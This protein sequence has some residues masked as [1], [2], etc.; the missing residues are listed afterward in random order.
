MITNT[1]TVT[2]ATTDTNAT[3]NSDTATTTVNA[4]GQG[5][6]PECDITSLNSPRTPGSAIIQSDLDSPGDE[7]LLVTGTSKNDILIIEPRAANTTQVRVKNTGRL[8]GTVSNSSFQ[9]IVVYALGGNDTIV[10]DPR[11]TRPA[12]IFG[13]DGN[14]SLSGG[15]GNDQISGGNGND[16]LFGNNGNDTL[17]GEAG[18]DNL[19]G[20]NGD[21]LEFGE[22]GS[23]HLYGDAGKDVL[24]GGDD[25]D[26]LYGGIDNDQLFGQ[27]GNDQLYGDAGN[28]IIV[29]GA[30]N[31]KLYGS[32]GRDILIGGIGA[33]QLNG[34]T[35]D[36]ILTGDS[37]TDDESPDALAAI[38]KKW[39]A[40][41]AYNFRVTTLRSSL[42]SNTVLDDGAADALFGDIGQDWYFLGSRDKIRDRALGESI[43]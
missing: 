7:V 14:D 8:L 43:S 27:A 12:L 28:D 16:S 23:D 21:D 40:N 37:T 2:S 11:I 31:D 38:L 35:A 4:I 6:L 26:F 34:E 20:G 10:I 32:A 22:M 42:N 13:G 36:D 24:L 41:L 1:G 9:N 25:N 17:C 18:N 29:G 15:G 19:H 3:N 33:D 30:G 39:T 5:G